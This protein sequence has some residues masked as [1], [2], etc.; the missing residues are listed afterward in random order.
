MAKLVRVAVA[1]YVPDLIRNEP[2]NIGVFLATRDAAAARIVGDQGDAPPRLF[3]DLH[4]FEVWRA[5]WHQVVREAGPDCIDALIEDSGA[6]HVIEAGEAALAEGEDVGS[7]VD[8]FFDRFVR[9]KDEPGGKHKGGKRQGARRL[10]SEIRAVFKERSLLALPKRSLNVFIPHPIV[11]R[12]PVAGTLDVPH[13]PTFVQEN[14]RKYVMEHVDF[15]V[16]GPAGLSGARDHALYAAYMLGDIQE[17]A[18]RGGKTDE[19]ALIAIVNRSGRKAV[20]EQ[21]YGLAAL[22]ALDRIRIVHWDDIDERGAF[23]RDRERVAL[24]VED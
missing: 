23:I 15:D 1:K 14:G 3:N 7:L 20:A 10:A 6:F 16:E 5:H 21:R 8:H 24:N 18:E 9:A 12:P 17:H 2:R 4:L 11:E 22:S 19:L 13:H